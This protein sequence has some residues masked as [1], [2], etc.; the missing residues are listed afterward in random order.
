MGAETVKATAEKLVAHCRAGT[1]AQGLAELYHPDAVSVEAMPMPGA[2]SA[3]ARGVE[4]IKGKHDWWFSTFELTGGKIEGPYVHGDDRFA[5][6]FAMETRNKAT[7]ETSAMQEVAVYTV[8]GAGKIVRE[9]FF[10]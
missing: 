6:I 3:E 1:E 8:D 4:A 10:Y 5:L 9:E 7:G 2:D